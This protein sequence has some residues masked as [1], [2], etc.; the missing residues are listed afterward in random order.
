MHRLPARTL[1]PGLRI[2][3]TIFARLGDLLNSVGARGDTWLDWMEGGRL[4]WC[5]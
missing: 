3:V 4:N 2:L 5:L 1:D